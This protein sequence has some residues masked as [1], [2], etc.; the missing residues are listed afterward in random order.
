MDTADI[1]AGADAPRVFLVDDHVSVRRASS[2]CCAVRIPRES[3]A[4]AREFLA[5]D[6]HVGATACLVL[7]MLMPELT[8]PRCRPSSRGLDAAIPIIFI[9]GNG[10]I[11]ASVRDGRAPSISSPS[12]SPRRCC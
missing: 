4:S 11:E 6:R 8:A 2:A 10:S 1:A 9:T 5:G 12:P 7:D 3:F